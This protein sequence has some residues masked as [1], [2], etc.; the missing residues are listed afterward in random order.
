MTGPSLLVPR[1]ELDWRPPSARRWLP[2]AAALGVSGDLLLRAAPGWNLA[3]WLAGLL[4]VGVTLAPGRPGR[5]RRAVAGL[6]LLAAAAPAV[7]SAPPLQLLAVGLVMVSAGWLLLARPWTSGLVARVT[8]LIGAGIS[9]VVLAP[10]GAA[11]AP[12]SP[13]E[14]AA[15]WRRNSA[16]VA[17]GAVVAA[18]ILLVVGALFISG[19]PAFARHANL[20]LEAGLDRVV[21]HLALA[22][23]LAW[24]AGGLV[25]AIAGVRVGNLALP[26]GPLRRWAGEVIVALL[27]V[28]VLFAVFLGVQ[29]RT[30]VG[31]R[32]FVESTIGMTYAEYA[33][34]GFFQLV[35]AGL[36]AIPTLLMADW[37]V[38]HGR[39]RRTFVGLTYGLVAGVILV[40]ASA[41]VRLE[42]YVDVYGLTEARL[43]AAAV[44]AWLATSAVWLA[45]TIARGRAERFAAGA[46]LAG[47]IVFVALV[48]VNPAATVVRTNAARAAAGETPGFDVQYG[49]SEL[50]VD[51]V[52]ALVE[53]LENLSPDERCR[54]AAH[55]AEWMDRPAERDWRSWTVSRW[56]AWRVLERHEAA[57]R[58]LARPCL[59]P[60]DSRA[61]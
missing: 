48:V 29:V 51:A 33:R 3:L 27:L 25:L 54:V 49:T 20:L 13:E 28:E 23:L 50:G 52:P 56:R 26:A 39:H 55:L 57:I 47:W 36:V 7:R 8:A 35:I 22:L 12:R 53:A 2:A 44:M 58:A 45:V 5:E 41:A 16:V 4:V 14:G 43:Y 32:E 40:V 17:R 37:V 6:G 42:L 46:L 24:V 31:G 10:V 61:G 15:R 18:P 11:V 34:S 1:G 59:D 19:D 38:G 9:M 60:A 21:S 30:L